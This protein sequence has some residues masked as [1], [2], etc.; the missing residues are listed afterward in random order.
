MKIIKGHIILLL[1]L[2]FT[3]TAEQKRSEWIS[4]FNGKDLSGWKI[5]KGDNGH[6]KVIDGVIDYDACSEAKSKKNRDLWTEKEYKDFILKIDWRLKRTVG[7][8][9]MREILPDGSYKLDK[10]DKPIIIKLPNADSGIYLR[11]S[12][13]SQVNI[14]CWPV[15][16]GEVYSY[17]INEDMPPAVRR[18]VTPKVNADNNIGEW[19]TFKIMLQGQYL[20]VELN[21]KTV[22]EG[23]HL[24]DLPE[25]GRIGLQHH[26]SKEDGKWVSP[27][28]LV[29][30]RNI[31][32]KE[33]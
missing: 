18:G 23:A 5:P 13:K 29:Q 20:T 24:P 6:W 3:L 30:F 16:S 17:R 22:I 12:R 10:N 32:I 2:A 21:G 1:L 28:S 8:H 19:N 4:L 31:Y 33:L 9:K 25:K 27:P 11:G 26:G 14:W 7:E 15:G